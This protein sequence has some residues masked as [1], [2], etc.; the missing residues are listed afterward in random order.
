[1][2]WRDY[3]AEIARFYKAAYP[4]VR[5]L[6]DAR[7]TGRLSGVQR[8]IDILIEGFVADFQFRVVIDGKYRSRKIDVTEVEQ[9]ISFLRDVG[10][11][12]GVMIAP[13]GYT[14]AAEERAYYDD[15]DV[16][17]DV[18]SLAE[19]MAFQSIGG[20]PFVGEQGVVVPAPLG[21]VIDIRVMTDGK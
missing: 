4:G 14:T 10:V 20:I 2:D 19:P 13:Q 15:L 8:Q 11:S 12:T 16:D 5:I 21:W 1:M 6:T 7:L 17:L 9:F 18:L 3:E